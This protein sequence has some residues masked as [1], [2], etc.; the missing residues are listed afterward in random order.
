MRRHDYIVSCL[1][2]EDDIAESIRVCH[3]GGVKSL[4]PKEESMGAELL[5]AELVA[6]TIWIREGH[7]E[8]H[9]Q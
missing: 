5:S 6:N 2:D 8:E 4:R 7:L 1:Q 3:G 9:K